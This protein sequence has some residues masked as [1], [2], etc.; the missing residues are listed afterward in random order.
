METGAS[1]P[2]RRRLV[3]GAA[4]GSLLVGGARAAPDLI[5]IRTDLET[6]VAI[7]GK[8]SGGPGDADSGAWKA[9]LR[10]R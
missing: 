3:A 5:S 9:C 1:D 7:G 10:V 4:A 6:W 8:A 2:T